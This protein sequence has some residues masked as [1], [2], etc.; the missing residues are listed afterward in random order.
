MISWLVPGS[1]N[2]KEQMVNLN[3]WLKGLFGSF[4]IQV[5]FYGVLLAQSDLTNNLYKIEADLDTSNHLLVANQTVHYVNNSGVE[6][7]RIYVHLWANA[8][9]SNDTELVTQQLRLGISDAYFLKDSERGGYET[10]EFLSQGGQKLSTRFEEGSNEILIIELS[11]PLLVGEEFIFRCNYTLKLPKLITRFGHRDNY[12]QLTHWYPKVAKCENGLWHAM[13]YLSLGE[14]Y[15]DFADYDVSINLPTGFTLANTGSQEINGGTYKIKAEKVVDFAC[16]ASDNFSKESKELNLNGQ[17]VL[18]QVYK[19]GTNQNWDKALNHLERSLRFFSDEVGEYPYPQVSVVLT[20]YGNSGMEYPMITNIGAKDSE[21]H[22]DH[23]IAHEVG[24]NWFYGLIATNERRFP[25]MDEG[26]TTFYDHKYNAQFYGHDPYEHDPPQLFRKS[27]PL[28]VLEASIVARSRQNRLK[29][30]TLHSND[31]ALIDYGISI[32][33]RTALGF[34]FLESFLGKEVFKSCIQ[35]Y[36]NQFKFG[37]PGP[38][39]LQDVF[40]TASNQN[41]NWFFQDYLTTNQ[42]SDFTIKDQNTDQVIIQ[43]S[44]ACLSPYC[45]DIKTKEGAIKQMWR[46]PKGSL[47]TINLDQDIKSISLSRENN[48]IDIDPNNDQKS[49][50]KFQLLSGIDDPNKKQ[51]FWSPYIAYNVHDNAMLGISLYNS[52]YPQKRLRW[53]LAPAISQVSNNL[54]LSG[55]VGFQ[56][57]L[58]NNSQHFR[59]LIAGVQAKSFSYLSSEAVDLA[60]QKLKPFLR[61]YL[62]DGFDKRSLRY[63]ELNSHLINEETA[64]FTTS[65]LILDNS[66]RYASQLNYHYEE[67]DP[68]ARL[69][70]ETSLEFQSY[71]QLENESANYLKI[72]SSYSYKY[73][74]AKGKFLKFRLF[75]SYFLINTERES[76]SYANEIT[77]GSI[78]LTSQG[79]TDQLYDD[80]YFGRN[81]Q[82]GLLSRQIHFGEGNFKNALTS[83][84]NVGLSNHFA[85]ALNFEI[86]TPLKIKPYMDVGYYAS[87]VSKEAEFSNTTLYSIGFALELVDDAIGIYIPLINSKEISDIYS[88]QSFF[89]RISFTIDI[90]KADPWKIE[91]ELY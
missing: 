74:F 32:Y 91:E 4:F 81:R 6:L 47:D 61:L 54:K 79:F 50:L 7:D 77:R 42:A 38:Q 52:A 88:T 27:N 37:H 57:D 35:K 78:A 19:N 17:K 63:F 89:S 71:D 18:C 87:K 48:I 23:L 83:A 59:K 55:L 24:H 53:Y 33:E 90:S 3:K 86:D 5:L 22:V 11:K 10:I 20:G 40:E 8:L 68:I 67:K 56:Y 30:S 73:Q 69:M 13:P 51:I 25:W 34:K 43:N 29:A 60:Y 1:G 84:Y 28:S 70:W 2:K 9:A 65:D 44:G 49:K 41:L 85:F 36:Y 39:D 80:F 82:T 16:F 14:Y 26:L 66:F 31:Y 45:L 64:L 76:A 21:E 75:G 58:I 46:S 62:N 72:S 15:H 12:Y